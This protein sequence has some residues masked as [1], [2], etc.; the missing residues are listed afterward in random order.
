[1]NAQPQFAIKEPADFAASVSILTSV[2]PARISKAFYLNPDGDLVKEPGGNMTRGTQE[3]RLVNNLDDLAEIPLALTPAQALTYGIPRNGARDVYDRATFDRLGDATGAT[4][5]TKEMYCWPSGGGVLM[6]DYD[7]QNDEQTL[8]R[9]QLVAAIRG[10]A[11][12]LSDVA[13]LWFPSAGS[14]I[15]HRNV[16]LRGVKGQRLWF[17]VHDAADIPRAGKV[18][19][20]RLWLA[21]HG[22]FAVSKSG[23][24]L[25]RTL[26]DT[27]V[28]QTNRLDFAGGSECRGGLEQ[29]R[30]KPVRVPG[31]VEVIDTRIALAELTE[32]ERKRVTALKAAARE[33]MRGAADMQ[34]ST[35]AAER[36]AAAVAAAGSD[37]AAQEAARASVRRAL[38]GSLPHNFPLLV[39]IEGQREPVRI[40]VGEVLAEPEQWDG[41][42]TRDPLDPEAYGGQATGKLF[43]MQPQPALFSFAHGGS[44]WRLEGRRATVRIAAGRMNDAVNQVVEILRNDP[45]AYD[46]GPD[47]VF[48]DDGKIHTMSEALASYY[49]GGKVAFEKYDGRSRSHVPCDPPGNMVKQLLALKEARGLKRLEAVVTAPVIRRDGTVL[50]RPGYDERTRLFLDM[51]KTLQGR[52]NDSPTLAEAH[53]AL[54]TLMQPFRDFPFVNEL[55]RGAMLAALLTAAVRPALRSAPAFGFEAPARGSGKTLLAQCIAAL[56][57]DESEVWPH[58]RDEDEIRK[59]LVTIGR[60]GRRAVVWDNVVGTFDSPALAAFLTG[61]AVADRVLG[62]SEYASFPNRCLMLMTG[63]NMSLVGDMT[64]RVIVSRIDAGMQNP[65][66]RRFDLDPLTYVRENRQEMVVAACTLIRAALLHGEAASPNRVA[67]FEDWDDLVRQTVLW[68]GKQLMAGEYGDPMLLILQAQENDPE[69]DAVERLFCALS[70]IFGEETF[71]CNDVCKQV[72]EFGLTVGGTPQGMLVEAVREISPKT[73]NYDKINS[74][75]LGHVLKNRVDRV[76]GGL[77][78][79]KWGKSSGGVRYSIRKVF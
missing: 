34:R 45:L 55:A 8:D 65:F 4:A 11:P 46:Y 50:D 70:E 71:L 5:R 9:D 36:E 24:L 77:K 53:K 25:E 18:L 3:T 64:R 49:I 19:A 35:F 76:A 30:G 20:D 43:L 39:E 2:R 58:V 38:A 59:R 48:I 72:E 29:R 37:L 28:W 7:P 31:A 40:T 57:G 13:A 66:A 61:S 51:P 26:I 6:L 22:Y 56:T 78:L 52:V 54:V 63:N 12:G 44:R 47:L 62:V 33:A 42:K 14:C 10:A 74:V 27:S 60:T 32:A 16:E 17:L 68:C 41:L 23:S 73:I 15:W 69:E 75:S 21:G 79:L 1:M 67:S